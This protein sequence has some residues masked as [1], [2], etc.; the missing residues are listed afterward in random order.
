M[1]NNSDMINRHFL[2]CLACYIMHMPYRTTGNNNGIA[3][4]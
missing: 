1:N 2:G 4:Q 3:S